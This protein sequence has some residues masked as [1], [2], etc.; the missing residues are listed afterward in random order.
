MDKILIT[1]GAGY[2]GSMLSTD[3]VN[4]G[5][6]VT[7]LDNFRYSTSSLDHLLL[8]KNF[9]LVNVD[10]LNKS[11]LKKFLINSDI[12]IPLAALV[13]APLCDKFKKLARVT[14]YEIIKFIVNN[15]NS[16][17]KLIFTNS[18]SGYGIGG[19][20]YCD[21]SSALN[22]I[23]LYGRTKVLAEQEVMKHNNYVSLRL[24]TVFGFSYRMRTDLL[25]NNFVYNAFHKKKI[26][27]YEENFKRNFIHVKDVSET[28]IKIIVK[29]NYFKN[30]IYN[31]GLSNAN[32]TKLELANKIKKHLKD[33]KIIKNNNKSD[34]DKRDYFIS[35]KKIENKGI[36]P[37]VSLEQGIEELIK[38]FKKNKNKIVNN[39]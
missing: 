21:E 36:Y 33:L 4:L 9:H 1:G 18:N 29:F 34:P 5:Y 7:V 35:N 31:L 23:S 30:N 20:K 12:I 14:N 19:S 13:G 8:R 27:L 25:V 24:A 22:P 6:R 39:Y 16:K 11:I 10:I 38:V 28:I 2:I 17:Q 37:K 32:L 15:L 26:S 3:L